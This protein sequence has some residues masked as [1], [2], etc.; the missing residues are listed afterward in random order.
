MDLQ[1]APV[2]EVSRVGGSCLGKVCAGGRGEDVA[3]EGVTV[4]AIG[5]IGI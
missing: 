5:T 2:D 3:E 4:E 1:S